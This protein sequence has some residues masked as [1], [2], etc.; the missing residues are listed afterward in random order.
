MR[1]RI[2]IALIALIVLCSVV[3]GISRIIHE[4][5]DALSKQIED[6][7]GADKSLCVIT[8]DMIEAY[9]HTYYSIRHK[10]YREGKNSNQIEGE[11]GEFDYSYSVIKSK[12]LSGVYLCNA[13]MGQDATVTYIIESEIKSGNCRIVIT[14]SKGKIF[15]EIPID[16]KAEVS[17]VAPKDE[18][19]MVKCVGESAAFE[20]EIKRS[21]DSR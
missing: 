19:F 7:N 1:K 2:I 14:D 17:F 6:Q 15:R 21:D 13:Y 3:I 9:D 10:V 11:L 18:I 20:I 16:Q 12:M 8:D 5:N 4:Y